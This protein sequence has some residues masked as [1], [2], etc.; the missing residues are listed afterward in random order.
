MNASSDKTPPSAATG[1]KIETRSIDYVPRHERHGK[2]WHQG[3]FW[4]T[5]NFVL[6]TMITGFT[7]AALGLGLVYAILAIVIGVGLGTFAMAFHANQGPRMGLP[8]MIQSRAQFGLRGAIV[9]FIAVIFVYIGF[10]VFNVILATDAINTVLPGSRA[11]W[12]ALIVL[13]VVIA[14]I[15]HDL[16][17]TVQRWLTYVMISVFAV[18]TVAALMTLQADAAVAGA[19]FSWS[20]FLIQLCAAAGYQISYAVYVSDYSRYLPHHTPS[21]S[22]IFWTYLGAAGSALWLMSLGAFLASALPSPDAIG[23]VREVGNQLIPGFGTFTVLIAVPALIGIMAVNCYGAMLTGIS[24][25]DGFVKIRP[26]L[27]SRVIGIG[28]VAVVIFLIALSIPDSYLA[29]FNTFVL[30]MLYFL[31]P[32][33]A[34]NLADFYVVRKGQYA[35]SDIFNPAGIYGQW[36]KAGLVAYGLGMVSMI[37][38]MSLS[39]YEGPVARALGGADITFVVGLG[40]SAVVY[41]LMSRNLDTLA[42]ARAIAASEALLEG[43]RS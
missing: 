42:E 19:H 27:K 40:V 22:V 35:I 31:V 20:A 6:T 26:R 15:G 43:Q 39:F 7:G 8:Q 9:P 34:V 25:I 4:F 18:L 33:T 17:H 29:S 38:F 13:A 10:N 21:R 2:V 30:L 28:L 24:A 14:V 1:L 5:G 41:C 37:P 23:S 3:P 12:Y 32:W 16:L 11:P 36:G